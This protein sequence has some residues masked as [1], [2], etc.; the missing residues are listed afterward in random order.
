MPA[1]MTMTM[2][3]SYIYLRNIEINELD[4]YSIINIR[5]DIMI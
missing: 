2:E 3:T 1:A 5:I 4:G